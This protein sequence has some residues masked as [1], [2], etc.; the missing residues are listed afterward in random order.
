MK[1]QERTGRVQPARPTGC[2]QCTVAYHHALPAIPRRV[3]R[4]TRLALG[5]KPASTEYRSRLAPLA[6]SGRFLAHVGFHWGVPAAV[7]LAPWGAAPP[8]PPY[9]AVRPPPAGP[10]RAY[11]TPWGA[12]PPNPHRPAG[13]PVRFAAGRGREPAEPLPAGS[14]SAAPRRTGCLP[15]AGTVG[16]PHAAPPPVTPLPA[17]FFPGGRG[18]VRPA[19][20]GSVPPGRSLA[21][22]RPS[23]RVRRVFTVRTLT[24]WVLLP[25]WATRCRRVV[26]FSAKRPKSNRAKEPTMRTLTGSTLVCPRCGC[27]HKPTAAQGGAVQ[28]TCPACLAL[29][30]KKRP[31]DTETNEAKRS[32]PRRVRRRSAS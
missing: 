7:P 6:P 18:G 30:P 2:Q 5:H 17:P 26:L 15:A 29:P 32:K 20:F 24:E 12:A 21:V 16:G 8:N 23:W 13:T 25:M 11:P 10:C 1:H 19:R 27:S 31:Q 4:K 22:L 28:A 9:P 14:P 3:A